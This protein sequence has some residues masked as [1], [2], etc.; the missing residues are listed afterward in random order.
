M[1]HVDLSGPG[2]E[3]ANL[4]KS[5]QG[6]GAS[7]TANQVAMQGRQ[8]E[9]VVSDLVVQADTEM[10]L[11]HADYSSLQ[12]ETKMTEYDP[13]VKKQEE[14][15]QRW[16]LKADSYGNP[17]VSRRFRMH[18]DPKLG[19]YVVRGATEKGV[20]QKDYENKSAIALENN[21]VD[22]AHANYKDDYA[23][24]RSMN[25]VRQSVDSRAKTMGW[26][27]EQKK[28]EMRRATD[29][30]FDAR[31]RGYARQDPTT[32][33]KILDA[34]RSIIGGK[35]QIDLDLH[36]NEQDANIK[37]LNDGDYFRDH[38]EWPD[39][40]PV[41]V[42]P[43]APGPRSEAAPVDGV[44]PAQ[45]VAAVKG[46]DPAQ[47][48]EDASKPPVEG[49]LQP[50]APAAP[51]QKQD[52]SIGSEELIG[53]KGVQYAQADTGTK[54]DASGYELTN[55]VQKGDPKDQFEV[56]HPLQK[57]DPRE[58]YEAKPLKMAALGPLKDQGPRPSKYSGEISLGDSKFSFVSGGGRTPSAP[59]G[60]YP[61]TPG[62]EGPIIRQMGGITLNNNVV[63]DPALGRDRHG[64]AFHPAQGADQ[65]AGCFI[66]P[67]G[68]WPKFKAELQSKMQTEGPQYL[69]V[70]PDGSAFISGK[71]GRLAND[72]IGSPTKSFG[73]NQKRINEVTQSPH[74][75]TIIT[76]ANKLGY[77]TN[78]L[79]TYISIESSGNPRMVTG[80]YYGLGQLSKEEF[81][82][83]SSPGENIYD[84][85]ANTRATI[86]LL[87][88]NSAM[89]EKK[90]GREPSSTELYMIHQQGWGGA[91]AHF[92]NP[93]RP[94]WQ[95]MASTK[96][97]REKGE[98]WSRDAIWGNL[99]DK[100]KKQYG[101]VENVRSA[102]LVGT[103][104]RK[105][106]GNGYSPA[107]QGTAI[108]WDA[109][110]GDSAQRTGLIPT[111]LTSPTARGM[112]IPTRVGE[113]VRASDQTAMVVTPP[114]DASPAAIDTHIN[115]FLE[116][117]A[118]APGDVF[119]VQNPDGGQQAYEVTASESGEKSYK[120]AEMLSGEGG[121]I[122]YAQADT[123][124][125]S[126]ASPNVGNDVT[127]VPADKGP[128]VS[129]GPLRK[130][131]DQKWLDQALIMAEERANKVAPGNI[132]YK[133]N[134]RRK[135]I[136]D[137]YQAQRM[138]V[139]EQRANYNN[140][141]AA[142]MGDYDEKMIRSMDQIYANPVLHES[143]KQLD[144]ARQT[145]IDAQVAANSKKDLLPT[146][147]RDARA[148][149]LT[150]LAGD[151]PDAFLDEPLTG[152]T[153][154]DIE[155]LFKMKLN[156]KKHL[157][158]NRATQTA[159]R[160]VGRLV[161]AAGIEQ[162][163]DD[164]EVKVYTEFAG[165][166]HNKVQEFIQ[167]NKRKP[168]WE[169]AQKIATQLLAPKGGEKRFLDPRT[170]FNDSTPKFQAPSSWT[171][172]DGVK[173]SKDEWVKEFQLRKQ[174]PPTPS[175]INKLWQDS[176]GNARNQP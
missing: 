109:S 23:F 153:K 19:A 40:A 2:Q 106:T 141:F 162:F 128:A 72:P 33:R 3:L 157:T 48:A 38:G 103:F 107:D 56:T 29:R 129:P 74:G 75:Q 113:G 146:P 42:Q 156:I 16:Q 117:N 127:P 165:A 52:A 28:A 39:A 49:Q 27:E 161:K 71:P 77:D 163:G 164:E 79:L 93:D 81:A 36:L 143:Y 121:A 61:I 13:Y 32:A 8:N 115:K 69:T 133:D 167:D 1:P 95:N 53:E 46:D 68:Q 158:E 148:D 173:R 151:D 120:K 22:D 138:G 134:L 174:R 35:T 97:G 150:G 85:G 136:T 44:S 145:Q 100:E 102:D 4:G 110:Q 175:E 118:L 65:S 172:P 21:A 17:E 119:K 41:V 142:V 15:A 76:E 116:Q 18:L 105:I 89:F 147:E 166:M 108:A 101:S 31:V 7:I 6:L 73:L 124:T 114:A 126:D 159:L 99:T 140:V 135:L 86:K 176:T 112:A 87:Q 30:V 82:K 55:P 88:A 122:Q 20:A 59:Y 47:I 144:R 130:D 92:A 91:Q 67:D 64:I 168:N 83:Y 152:M 170:W 123:G 149:Y 43:D 50:G 132:K 104:E 70:N 5:F 90:F 139:Q 45:Q 11:N 60:T 155:R 78:K 125:V 54:S 98:K 63:W 34:N 51:D 80:S 12:G 26:D 37:S 24:D 160:D 9:A 66:I 154:K 58:Q 84:P 94:A 62:K 111:R 25:A 14:T 96:E 131:S 171:G 57:G 10:G 169:D 137:F